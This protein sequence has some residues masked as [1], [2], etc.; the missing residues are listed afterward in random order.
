MKKSPVKGS[1]GDEV[2]LKCDV[3]MGGMETIGSCE[4]ADDVDMMREQ[5][6]TI[7]D[8]GCVGCYITCL[9]K[10]EYSKNLMSFYN[11]ISFQDL[12]VNRSDKDDFI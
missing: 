7:S 9:V 11:M 3:I 6:H 2:A 1:T 8:G 12:V 10:N 4:R 5:F